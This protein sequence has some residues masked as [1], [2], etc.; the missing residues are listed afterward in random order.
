MST[1]NFKSGK[2]LA[3]VSLEGK[4]DSDKWTQGGNMPTNHHLM[5]Q[6]RCLLF[7]WTTS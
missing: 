6:V 4:V 1:N 5:T 3:R 2:T 7:K